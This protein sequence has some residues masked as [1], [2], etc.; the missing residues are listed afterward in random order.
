MYSS[1]RVDRIVLRQGE[2][3]QQT[4]RAAELLNSAASLYRDQAWDQFRVT[5]DRARA[6]ALD[7]MIQERLAREGEFVRLVLSAEDSER[8]GNWKAAAAGWEK[9]DAIFPARQ[10]LAM[11]A[12][13][14]WLM[15]DEP[16]ESLRTLAP[17]AAH[18]G[19]PFAKQANQ[20]LSELLKNFPE[21]ATDVKAET[22]A[23]NL[24]GE[25]FE[26]IKTQE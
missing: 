14:A 25:E 9:S 2:A 18:Q 19:S 21:W 11:K 4:N 1:K 23:S 15:A 20:I 13:V 8:Q 6:L 12:A 7:P 24:S 17:L 16:R 3:K 5:V 22:A 10:W 26:L